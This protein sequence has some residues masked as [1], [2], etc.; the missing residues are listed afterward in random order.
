MAQLLDVFRSPSLPEPPKGWIPPWEQQ[1]QPTQP[2]QAGVQLLRPVMADPVVPGSSE[3]P[4]GSLTNNQEP[5]SAST[6]PPPS[7]SPTSNVNDNAVTTTQP[8]P[9]PPP[10]SSDTSPPTSSQRTP[11]NTPEPSPPSITPPPRTTQ[12][13]ITTVIQDGPTQRTITSIVD[14]VVDPTP[15]PRT[16]ISSTSPTATALPQS[17]TEHWAQTTGGIVGI[18]VAAVLFFLA[19]VF[20]VGLFVDNRKRFKKRANEQD[21]FLPGGGG[22]GPMETPA[23]STDTL[24]STRPRSPYGGPSPIP[25]VGLPGEGRPTI[26][27]SPYYGSSAPHQVGMYATASVP[28]PVQPLVDVDLTVSTPQPGNGYDA[29]VFPAYPVTTT[30]YVPYE[31]V[32]SPIQPA[33]TGYDLSSSAQAAQA[34]SQGW[35]RP[36]PVVTTHTNEEPSDTM[37]RRYEKHRSLYSAVGQTL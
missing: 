7:P 16:L 1:E 2:T 26:Q 10:A 32:M 5:G 11:D 33:S 4:S 36:D 25:P 13:V 34:D 23:T 15:A 14:V 30:G 21:P 27:R 19:G 17:T 22:G 29:A 24:L 37:E 31:P 35:V 28:Y 6:Q 3:V 8:S 12:R 20:A 9:S 18:T